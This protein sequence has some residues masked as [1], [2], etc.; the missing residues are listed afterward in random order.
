MNPNHLSP[1]TRGTPTAE[2]APAAIV[3]KVKRLRVESR[4]NRAVE[5]LLFCLHVLSWIEWFIGFSV[6][7]QY[8]IPDLVHRNIDV[9]H[10]QLN[11][12]EEVE[13]MC[14]IKENCTNL[15]YVHIPKVYSEITRKYPE[16]IVMEY[17]EG[18][19]I[20]EVLEEDYEI[21]AKQVLKFGFVTSLFHGFTHGDL[22]A[23]NI[24]FMKGSPYKLGILDFGIMHHIGGH[25]KEMLLEIACE[26]FHEPVEQTARK[27]LD[28]GIVLEPVDQI[29]KMSREKKQYIIDL[30]AGAI[31]R[32]VDR[33]D[34]CD[35]GRI[36]EFI[37]QLHTCLRENAASLDSMGFYLSDDFVKT[38][39]V[40]AMAHGVTMKLCK[41][42]YVEL[43]NKVIR[44]LFHLDL[45]LTK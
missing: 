24:L 28:S 11:F 16:V 13:N 7:Q 44:E 12:Q 20:S 30:L 8:K 5:E 10:R 25:F 9:L 29:R 19:K 33:S 39:L 4:L 3:V 37:Y 26:I 27:L 45:F 43:A 21:F 14:R 32:I 42:N 1:S 17:I 23:G 15:H 2:Q 38:Q 36:Y 18:E 6:L 34:S 31:Q 22:H 35:Q 41:D 40:I